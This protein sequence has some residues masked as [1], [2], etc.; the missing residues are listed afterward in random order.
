M[1]EAG[2]CIKHGF[3]LLKE[4]TLRI[5]IEQLAFHITQ[6]MCESQMEFSMINSTYRDGV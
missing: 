5:F 1:F 3:V 4:F 6:L 2:E